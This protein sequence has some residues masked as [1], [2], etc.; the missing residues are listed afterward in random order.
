MTECTL[1]QVLIRNHLR[2]YHFKYSSYENSVA[3][4]VSDV[5]VVDKSFLKKNKA[6]IITPKLLKSYIF[7]VA[8]SEILN[9]SK[10]IYVIDCTEE[11]EGKIKLYEVQLGSIC[12]G[13]G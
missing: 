11:K 1:F 8:V 3:N 4:I 9:N 6:K 12:R 10:K 2:F 13:D 5:K 7:C